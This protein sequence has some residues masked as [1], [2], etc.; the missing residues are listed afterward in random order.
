M[1]AMI[2]NAQ[3]LPVIAA[4]NGGVQPDVGSGG[5]YFV[6]YDEHT[7]PAVIDPMEFL[8]MRLNEPWQWDPAPVMVWSR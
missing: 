6:Y 5:S 2:I 3:T 7:P 4:L 8:R 1:I